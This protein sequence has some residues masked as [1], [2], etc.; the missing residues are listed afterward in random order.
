M[1]AIMIISVTKD[2]HRQQPIP[3]E[4]RERISSIV[5][6]FVAGDYSLEGLF[7]DVTISTETATSIASSIDDYGAKLV[8]LPSEAW[9]YSCCQWMLGFWEV[10]VDLYSEDEGRSDLALSI[11]V[12][13][14]GAGFEFYVDSVHVP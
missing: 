12:K 5:A 3:S 10:L 2:P 7:P 14:V 6:A 9:E 4:W 13:E 11:R 1:D 8:P